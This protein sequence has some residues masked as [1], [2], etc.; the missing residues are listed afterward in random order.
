[1]VNNES[2]FDVIY[3]NVEG[4]VSYFNFTRL[5]KRKKEKIRSIYEVEVGKTLYTISAIE[6]SSSFV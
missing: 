4:P 2:N 5:K 6:I 1:M 3:N